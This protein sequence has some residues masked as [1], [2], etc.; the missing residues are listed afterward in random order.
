MQSFG[1]GKYRA[2][3]VYIAMIAVVACILIAGAIAFHDRGKERPGQ[4]S[5]HALD[6]SQ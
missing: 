1:Q 4:P 6:Q 2:L 5:S 3:I